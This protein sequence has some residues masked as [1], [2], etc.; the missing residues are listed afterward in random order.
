MLRS[1]LG[2]I[3]TMAMTATS[4]DAQAASPNYAGPTGV[5]PVVEFGIEGGGDRI[6]TVTF[7]DGSRQSVRGGQGGTLA[8]GALWVP[9]ADLPVSLRA[10]VGFK[11][12]TTAADNV[13]IW[14]R[15]FPVE[16]VGSWH[17]S[18]DWR[19]GAGF[20]RHIRP[21]FTAENLVPDIA[22]NDGNGATLEVGWRVVALTYTTM[23]YDGVNANAIGATLIWPFGTR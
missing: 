16:V 17:L 18:P 15:R 3:A 12:Q 13:S 9:S 21:R 23:A 22:F 20:V 2:G 7:T 11:F 4:A 19:V 6:A 10:T 8:A 14:M 5:K 1:L